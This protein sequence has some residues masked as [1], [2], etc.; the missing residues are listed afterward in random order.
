MIAKKAKAKK[1]FQKSREAHITDLAQYIR[2]A[3]QEVSTRLTTD[4]EPEKVI[5]KGAGGFVFNEEKA[6]LGEMVQS[7][8]AARHTP[9]HWIIAWPPD[10]QPTEAQLHEAAQLF[11]KEMGMSGHQY[12][13][14]A[15]GNT[16]S[17]HIHIALSRVCPNTGKILKINKGFDRLAAQKAICVIAH[18]QGWKQVPG[19]KYE[20][21]PSGPQLKA[22]S[23]R[24]LSDAAR[25]AEIA[26]AQESLERRAKAL[27]PTIA[28]ATSWQDLHIRLAAQGVTYE[29]RKGGAVLK[30]GKNGFV[31]ASKASREASLRALEKRFNAPFERPQRL[32]EKPFE[33][34]PPKLRR[35][36]DPISLIVALLFHLLGLHRAA[37]TLLHTRQEL[38]RAAL[39]QTKFATA[40]QKWA[41]QSV[42]REEHS[43]ARKNL[44]TA[45]DAEISA[46]KVLS[47]SE[48]L[49]FCD[50]NNLFPKQTFTPKAASTQAG[51]G[52]GSQTIQKKEA[53]MAKEIMDFEVV[54]KALGADRY[55]LTAKED[56]P[57]EGEGKHFAY[58]KKEA[59]PDELTAT[60]AFK[61]WSTDQV[62]S[63]MHKVV[64]T[65]QGGRYG[66]YVT[67]LSA[68][69]HYIL[70]DDIN[71]QE[72]HEKAGKYAPALV[73]ESSPGN[74]QAVLKIKA[75]SDLRI[76]KVAANATAAR[77]NQE[78]GDPQV[79][80]GEQAW[81][82]PGFSNNKPKHRTAEGAPVVNILSADG[83]YCHAAQSIYNEEIQ[84]LREV[85]ARP[86]Q[87][88][89]EA[90]AVRGAIP[91][92][93][94]APVGIPWA[95][96]YGVHAFH[97]AERVPGL[98]G[99][100]LDYAVSCRL[101]AMGYSDGEAVRTVAHARE[102]NDAI[103]HGDT[104]P[105]EWSMEIAR[106]QGV[107]NSA[108]YSPSGDRDAGRLGE[109]A[110]KAAK[111]AER[112]YAKSI[113]DEQTQ[114]VTQEQTQEQTNKPARARRRGRS[115]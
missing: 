14:G 100:N 44:K 103:R 101:R 8:L 20:M 65:A 43:A 74:C 50:K 75:D 89:R 104:A 105:Q 60:G 87:E 68:E 102:W 78:C 86:T 81:R 80:N 17:T 45:Q 47:Y 38:E 114:K 64:Q 66:T 12:I 106:A 95:D 108:Y 23:P 77:I 19:I 52:E 94:T 36:L 30:F 6:Q 42:L 5:C 10:E 56:N 110:V 84:K 48:A 72:K 63:Q 69:T 33:P 54:H 109:N 91:Q 55:R 18:A 13:Y 29:K 76:A 79:K 25:S 96:V 90:P 3:R 28:A 21:S 73:C 67:P 82:M 2:D 27:A 53:S 32:I 83:G 31:K 11:V 7:C 35:D 1:E 49:N 113:R 93:D 4:A 51:Q 92:G 22:H 15:H 9:D 85:Q 46:I 97:L 59:G 98:T 41:A 115:R 40:S 58:G 34:A 99:R 111:R 57:L 70:I 61:G 37:R 39:R 26:T 112:E 16:D 71:S 24:G 62:R 88:Q 107:V